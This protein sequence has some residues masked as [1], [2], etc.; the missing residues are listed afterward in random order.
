MLI[1]TT[2]TGQIPIYEPP[3]TYSL[4]H[5]HKKDPYNTQEK[6]VFGDLII[7]TKEKKLTFAN[8]RDPEGFYLECDELREIPDNKDCE[9]FIGQYDE[10]CYDELI[11][12]DKY[13]FPAFGYATFTKDHILYPDNSTPLYHHTWHI[14]ESRTT[15]SSHKACQDWHVVCR[16]TD[17]LTMAVADGHGAEVFCRAHLGARFACESACEVLAQ[18]TS[19]ENSHRRIKEV[20]DRKVSEDLA[21]NPLTDEEA[22]LMNI[23]PAYCAYGT[24]LICVHITPAGIYRL[25]IGDGELHILNHSGKFFPSLPRDAKTIDGPSSMIDKDACESMRWDFTPAEELPAAVILYTDGYEAGM[26]H[27][28]EIL[29]VLNSHKGLPDIFPEDIL[30]AGDNGDDQTIIMAINKVHACMQYFQSGLAEE[31]KRLLFE[32]IQDHL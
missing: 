32:E 22:A 11:I 10:H 24:T 1:I 14:L 4:N 12:E 28:W 25:H 5:E 9:I 23:L 26:N 19:F 15:G 2:Y 30:L 16:G 20:F 3:L 27:P 17:Y 8:M 31:R 7:E 29:E 13:I 6:C 18:A 21:A